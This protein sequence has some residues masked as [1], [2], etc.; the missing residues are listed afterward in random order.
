MTSLLPP[1]RLSARPPLMGLLVL[2]TSSL[3]AQESPPLRG[4]HGDTLVSKAD[5]A[6]TIIVDPAF[7]YVGSQTIDILK[8]AGADQFFFIQAGP[9][10]TIRR[11][12]WFQF[13]YFYPNNSYQYNYSGIPN[14]KP[15]ALGPLSFTG[16]I[17]TGPNYFTDDDRPGS[18]SRAAEQFLRGKGFNIAGTFI[19]LRMFH[20]TDATKRRELM[21]IYGEILP[22][23]NAEQR[24][25]AEI[26][27]HA[28]EGLRVQ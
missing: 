15:V 12:Y 25:R 7:R 10:S 14:R 28:K 19:T 6:V 20:L 11:F 21:I 9:D 1:V 27:A 16:D 2:L 18:D 23:S 26:T 13:E 17:R 22:D 24:I 5:P 8:V 3:A 4:V